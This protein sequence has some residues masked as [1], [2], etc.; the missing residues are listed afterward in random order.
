M[1]YN[2]KTEGRIPKHFKNYQNLIEFFKNLR[3]DNVHPQEVLKNQINF[4]SDLGKRRKRNPRIESKWQISVIQNVE[5]FLDFR[6]KIINV[7]RDYSFLLSEAKYKAKY[8]TGLK[9][10]N[11][12]QMLQRLSI[13]LA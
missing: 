10:L 3:D 5:H 1:I 4:K 13:E 8:G 11:P 2:Y 9:I 6:E 12:K 7:S